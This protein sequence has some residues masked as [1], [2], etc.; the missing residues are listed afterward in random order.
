[1]AKVLR[2]TAKR[3]G[4]RRAGIAHPAQPTD[5]PLDSLSDDQVEALKAEPMLVVEEI[6]EKAAQ[7]AKPQG[8]KAAETKAEK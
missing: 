3:D 5:H 4:F 1:M 6:E 7:G 2:I 8:A